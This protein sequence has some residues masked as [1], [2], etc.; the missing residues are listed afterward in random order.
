MRE[1][2]ARTSYVAL[3][4]RDPSG[5]G[6][7]PVQLERPRYHLAAGKLPTE[8]AAGGATSAGPR[9]HLGRTVAGGR[10]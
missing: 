1:I 4:D 8:S 9:H 10:K 3:M 7:W 2:R 5:G 6:G